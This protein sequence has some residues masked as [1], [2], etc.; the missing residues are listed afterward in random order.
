MKIQQCSKCKD[1]K[2]Y[3]FNRT[4]E[5]NTK[6]L[7]CN[8]CF[9]KCLD[10]CSLCGRHTITYSYTSDNQP[11][12]KK[13]T[14]QP[15]RVCKQCSKKFPAGRGR[16]CEECSYYNTLIK[17]ISVL[18]LLLSKYTNG[19]FEEFTWW[20]HKK[21]GSIFT[22]ASIQKYF[23]YFYKF[24]YIA[25]NLSR[26]PN[27]QEILNFF[28]KEK[29]SKSL[30]ITKFL[31]QKKI[32]IIDDKY[33]ELF[34]NLHIIDNYISY[35]KPYTY[36]YTLLNTYHKYLI[37][38]YI[39]GQTTI[40]SVRLALT[41]AFKVLQYKQHFKS[42]ILNDSI[43]NGY[44]WIYP[45]QMNAL[46]GFSNFVNQHHKGNLH[47]I[48]SKKLLLQRSKTKKDILQINLINLLKKES[49][50][51]FE[52]NRVL[53]TSIE[54]FHRVYVPKNVYLGIN[55]ISKVGDLYHICCCYHKFYVPEQLYY[56]L[57]S[58]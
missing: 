54:Y 53:R 4:L 24:D 38:K 20:L 5:N 1:Y 28:L 9:R 41:P 47:Q 52:K 45:G 10:I 13:C 8:T 6:S 12:C 34:S 37:N 42:C 58:I 29:I 15:F 46:V 22:T 35:F 21:R 31:V 14:C 18:N 55:N 51:A 2:K 19:L 17:K 25:N 11:M 32:I 49:L 57:L 48:Q 16:V 43:I 7:L 3:V 26:F 40:H 39:Q 33:K 36:E 50:T 44:L 23:I 27:Y 30:L 56:K